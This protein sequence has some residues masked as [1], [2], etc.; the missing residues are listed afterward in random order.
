MGDSW[1]LP[2]GHCHWERRGCSQGSADPPAAGRKA[3]VAGAGRGGGLARWGDGAA[4]TRVTGGVQGAAA[5]RLPPSPRGL[6]CRDG[7]AGGAVPALPL[8]LLKLRLL[9]ARAWKAQLSGP[10]VPSGTLLF[11]PPSHACRPSSTPHARSRES[12]S[13]RARGGSSSW[14]SV[15]AAPWRTR[16]NCSPPAGT[17][18]VARF[19]SPPPAGTG[20]PCA[21]FQ[22]VAMPVARGTRTALPKLKMLD[23]GRPKIWPSEPR[24]PWPHSFGSESPVP[25]SRSTGHWRPLG[26]LSSRPQQRGW[27]L[28][29]ASRRR[30]P[31]CDGTTSHVPPQLGGEGRTDP[32]AEG[33]PE[34][35]AQGLCRR[36]SLGAGAK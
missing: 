21:C 6:S 15:R 22:S 16:D 25:G 18:G 4:G 35:R 28:G 1:P 3:A 30:R 27:G 32:N 31:S 34:R 33:T 19:R 5:S 10:Q 36:S 20:A 9:V 23:E 24:T 11:P 2:G 13:G 7:A 17:P 8:P 12:G 14:T 26:T 29:S